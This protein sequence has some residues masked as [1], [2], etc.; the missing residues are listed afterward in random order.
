MIKNIC[1]YKAR[2]CCEACAEG[3]KTDRKYGLIYSPYRVEIEDGIWKV[4]DV[5]EAS[6]AAKFC[7][8]CNEDIK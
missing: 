6:I 4:M 1:G 3:F 7:A 5:E 2:F 8:Y